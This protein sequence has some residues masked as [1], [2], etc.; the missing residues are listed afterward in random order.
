M[1]LLWEVQRG[2]VMAVAPV[3]QLFIYRQT[4]LLAVAGLVV[5]IR[6]TLLVGGLRRRTC[7]DPACPL[8]DAEGRGAKPSWT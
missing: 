2:L 8:P 6:L 7:S 1:R 3:Y 5:A 4:V